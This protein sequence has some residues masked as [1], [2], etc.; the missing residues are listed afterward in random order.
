LALQAGLTVLILAPELY[1]PFRRLGAEYHASADGLAV[2]QRLFELLDAAPAVGARGP[3]LAPSPAAAPI[4]CEQVSFSYPARDA[5]V[6]ARLNLELFPGE[7]VALVGESGA[8]KSTV[9]ALL[10]GLLAPSAG[11][12][13]VDGV[14]LSACQPEAWHAL[15]S[16]VPQHPIL[17]RGTVEQNIRLGESTA[18]ERAV[19]EA[20]ELAAADAFIR[21]LPEGYQTVLGDGGRSLSSGERRRIGLARAFLKDAPLVVLDEP[22]AD[23]DPGSV[24][25]VSDA[26]GRLQAGRTMLLIAH[27]T[28]MIQH[29]D[30]VVRLAGGSVLEQEV[31]TAA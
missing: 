14:P 28:E 29:A 9:A 30:R 15:T 24:A 17:F 20:A 3:R 2:A 12:I 19:R 26:I 16:W 23:L 1:L 6:L 10:L 25:L 5:L 21:A 8:G 11:R 4:R 31:R 18:S 27:C 13:T 7:T 22:T